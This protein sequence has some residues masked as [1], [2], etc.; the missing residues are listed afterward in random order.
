MPYPWSAGNTLT[1]SDL[2]AAFAGYT[3]NTQS[4]AGYTLVLTDRGKLVTVS[5]GSAQNLTIPLNSSVAFAT[6]TWVDVLNIGAGTWTV[7]ATGGVTLS[8]TTA[9]PT[10]GRVRLTKTGTDTWYSSAMDAAVGGGLSLVATTTATA[11]S[12]VS[13][14]NCFTSTYDN[15]RI[16]INGVG[17]TTATVL[18]MRLRAS[19]VDLTSATYRF[20]RTD[21]QGAV[22]P[23][24]TTSTTGTSFATMF[25]DSTYRNGVSFD[26]YAPAIA[27]AT[28]MAGIGVRGDGPAAMAVAG[29]NTSALA[30]DGLTLFVGT[31]SFTTATNGIK[32]YGYRNS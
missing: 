1:A 4:G 31:G 10:N 15:Y 3:V 13:I 5:N 32:V 20:A 16:V 8:G 6:G 28:S 21:L 18:E 2:N 12:T 27:A 19:S 29:V 14:N 25:V 23:G 11:A 17:S 26:V 22:T 7:T 30:Y 9:I 24:G